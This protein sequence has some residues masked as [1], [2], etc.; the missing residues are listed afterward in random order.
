MCKEDDSILAR[1]SDGQEVKVDATVIYA[2][3]PAD[4]IK[5]H[6]AWQTR[7]PEGLVRPLSR[8]V[9]R[10]AISQFGVEEVYST[11]RG[12]VSD[13]ISNEMRSSNGQ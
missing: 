7:Y 8:G 13:L 5:V 4:V 2:I 9:I 10:D 6:I 12:E 1:T 3:N 11:K